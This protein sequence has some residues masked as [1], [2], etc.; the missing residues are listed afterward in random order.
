MTHRI[1]DR[2]EIVWDDEEK[3][4]WLCCPTCGETGSLDEHT[5]TWSDGKPT[6]DASVIC[7]CGA[8]FHIAEGEYRRA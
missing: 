4:W 6:I 8:H 5:V 2:G 1:P 3:T 7:E